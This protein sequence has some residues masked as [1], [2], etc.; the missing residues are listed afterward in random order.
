MKSNLKQCLYSCNLTP[1][2]RL[3]K[4]GPKYDIRDFDNL[5]KIKDQVTLTT[6]LNTVA[7]DLVE[8]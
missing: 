7:S 2:Q 6:R 3:N 8:I 4:S 5:T 1:K